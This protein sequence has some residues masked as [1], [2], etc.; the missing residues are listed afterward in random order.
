MNLLQKLNDLIAEVNTSLPNCDG[1]SVC[2]DL[3]AAREKLEQ[4]ARYATSEAQEALQSA[5]DATE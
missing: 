5:P 4:L 3:I 2:Q 1:E